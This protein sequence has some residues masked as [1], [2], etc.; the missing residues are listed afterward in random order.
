[1]KIRTIRDICEAL[2]SANIYHAYIFEQVGKLYIRVT[3]SNYSMLKC[4]DGIME[5]P[6][7]VMVDYGWKFGV[8]VPLDFFMTDIDYCVYEYNYF[9]NEGFNIERKEMCNMA[10]FRGMCDYVDCNIQYYKKPQNK[11]AFKYSN[12]IFVFFISI[13]EYIKFMVFDK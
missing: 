3:P 5:F 7:N 1:M 13:Y 9:I 4:L 12:S 11:D 2:F 10:S 6:M 8:V